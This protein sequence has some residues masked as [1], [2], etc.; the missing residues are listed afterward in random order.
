MLLYIVYAYQL[1]IFTSSLCLCLGDI[2]YNVNT[3]ANKYGVRKVAN[4]ATLSLASAYV[5]SIVLGLTQRQSFHALPM[6]G[7]HFGLLVYF[8][9]NYNILLQSNK[10]LSQTN[11]NSDGSVSSSKIDMNLT[12]VKVFYKSIWNLFYLEYC[13]Y[14]FI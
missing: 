1:S 4:F 6:V 14:P 5:G 8:L 13:L 2:K 9:Y 11:K 10:D 7:G 3:F 12:S